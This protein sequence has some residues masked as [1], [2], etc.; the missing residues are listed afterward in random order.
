VTGS[1]RVRFWHERSV[2]GVASLVTNCVLESHKVYGL[3]TVSVVGVAD[4][5]SNTGHTLHKKGHRTMLTGSVQFGDPRIAH[6]TWLLTSQRGSGMEP[7]VLGNGLQSAA[8]W[9]TRSVVDVG[10]AASNSSAAQSLRAT[11]T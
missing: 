3:H 9:Q 1:H 6:A 10:A 2:L 5:V 7:L 4:A 11:Q 8:R